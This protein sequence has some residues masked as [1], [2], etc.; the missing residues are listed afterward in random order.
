MSEDYISQFYT[1]STGN[2]ITAARLNGNVSNVTDG[3]SGGSKAANLGK[4]LAVLR[5]LILVEL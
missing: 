3:L 4:L 1:W 5:L 2:T